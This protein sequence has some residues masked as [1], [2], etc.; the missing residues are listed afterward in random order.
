MGK[1]QITQLFIVTGQKTYMTTMSHVHNSGRRWGEFKD[2][3][4]NTTSEYDTIQVFEN[5]EY[6]RWVAFYKYGNNYTYIRHFPGE[7]HTPNVQLDPVMTTPTPPFAPGT[8]VLPARAGVEVFYIDGSSMLPYHISVSA[9]NVCST[10]LNLGDIQASSKAVATSRG[11]GISDV[12]YVGTDNGMY[13]KSYEAMEW[14]PPFN[15]FLKIGKNCIGPPG[16]VSRHRNRIDLF[17]RS[18]PENELLYK[19]WDGSFWEPAE[20]GFKNMGGPEG[21]GSVFLSAPTAVSRGPDRLDVFVIGKRNK[22]SQHC[23]LYHKAMGKSVWK[24]KIGFNDMGGSFKEGVAPVVTVNRDGTMDIFM[25][26]GDESRNGAY[27]KRWDGAGDHLALEFESL[28]KWGCT[29][30]A[31]LVRYVDADKK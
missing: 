21:P 4:L 28:Y 25:I 27:H 10:R 29:S 7:S 24:P 18:V 16:A 17:V 26:G 8:S 12:F 22:D 2:V 9:D 20:L 5:P 14:N 13:W 3:G 11:P 23:R 19:S 30:I 31:A 1:Q 15:K 6:E